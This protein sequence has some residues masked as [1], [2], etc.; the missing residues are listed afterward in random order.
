MPTIVC[1]GAS[2]RDG[3]LTVGIRTCFDVRTHAFR[4]DAEPE[5]DCHSKFAPWL[6]AEVPYRRANR[7]PGAGDLLVYGPATYGYENLAAAPRAGALLE[8][9][10]GLGRHGMCRGM[11]VARDYRLRA[12]ENPMK[13]YIYSL[14][15][16]AGALGCSHNSRGSQTAKADYNPRVKAPLVA[17]QHNPVP[18]NGL[19]SPTA[20]PK[21]RARDEIA[22]SGDSIPESMHRRSASAPGTAL[23]R[24]GDTLTPM[25]QGEGESDLNLTQALR[26]ALVANE[27]LSFDSKNI[28]IIS[29]DG[30]VTL[31]GSVPTLRE[32]NLIDE[33]ATQLAGAH[34]VDN[35]LEVSGK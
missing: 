16:A 3:Y 18:G 22:S 28:K 23:D 10:E 35:Q 8:Q 5:A 9:R 21:H 4:K 30:K 31:R 14:L 33:A 2:Q 29:R 27:A 19:E 1:R 12:Q 6:K 26:S 13:R 17:G 24:R 34:Y 20:L 25:D 11:A 15:L 7:D 32:R